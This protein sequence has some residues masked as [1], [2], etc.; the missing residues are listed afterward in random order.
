M[1]PQEKQQA[2]A[3]DVKSLLTSLIKLLTNKPAN[4]DAT[5][6]QEV[7]ILFVPL[8]YTKVFKALKPETQS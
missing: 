2:I 1:T 7:A 5:W 8:C 4:P 3:E 6:L